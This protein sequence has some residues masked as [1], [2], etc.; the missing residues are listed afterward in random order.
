MLEIQRIHENAITPKRSTPGD[1][2]LD[3]ASTED[4]TLNHEEVKLIPTGWK[5]AVP[6]GFEIQIRPR[7]GLA[8]KNK[9]MVLNSPGT[10]DS[11]YRGEIK[12]ILYNEG[13]EPFVIKKGDRIAQMVINKVELWEPEIKEELS[14]T[15]RGQG[16]F[17]STGV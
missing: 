17:G 5:M 10:V 15:N 14:E 3:L 13:K 4:I 1:A 16:G 12:V 6:L 2:G 8:L 11:H 7:S 9:I